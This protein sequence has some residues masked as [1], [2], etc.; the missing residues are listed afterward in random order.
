MDQYI[1]L[2]FDTAKVFGGLAAIWVV[3]AVLDF[4]LTDHSNDDDEVHP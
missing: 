1:Q 3:L 4:L 2:A